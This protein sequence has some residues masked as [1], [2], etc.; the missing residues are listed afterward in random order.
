MEANALVEAGEIAV[1][2]NDDD[3]VLRVVARPAHL[4]LLGRVAGL[5][6]GVFATGQH[7]LGA[8]LIKQLIGYVSA[9]LANRGHAHRR[10]RC[11]Y[12]HP[13]KAAVA[14]RLGWSFCH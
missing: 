10:R 13:R 1:V 8:Q 6:L 4:G 12:D 14:A 7:A 9:G 5:Q 3:A 2:R 11:K